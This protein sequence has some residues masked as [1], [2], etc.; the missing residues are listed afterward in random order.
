MNIYNG[1]VGASASGN[2]VDSA[3]LIW[4]ARAGQSLTTGYRNIFLGRAA[5]KLITTSIGTIAIGDSALRS[6]AGSMPGIVAIGTDALGVYNRN[7][8]TGDIGASTA[9][10]HHALRVNTGFGNVAIGHFSQ[11]AATSAQN[12]VSIGTRSLVSVRSKEHTSE[13][14]SR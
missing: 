13:L 11:A 14:Q 5:G 12:N 6:H 7:S 10:G 4:G 1:T 9:I 8:G 3:N 2:A